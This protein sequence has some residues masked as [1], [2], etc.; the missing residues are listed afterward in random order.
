MTTS[1]SDA[2]R[3]A[4]GSFAIS[5]QKSSRVP[6]AAPDRERK[7]ASAPRRAS[8]P[9]RRCTRLARDPRH[10]SGHTV[11]DDWRSRLVRAFR[12][13]GVPRCAGGDARQRANAG[14]RRPVAD[15][16]QQHVLGAGAGQSRLLFGASG[17]VVDGVFMRRHGL[18]GRV[19]SHTTSGSW[20][21]WGWCGTSLRRRSRSAGPSTSP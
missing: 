1:P 19:R 14:Q 7:P 11:G 15:E 4:G 8:T 6:L 2:S 13:K 10:S 20:W 18:L 3:G 16:H 21:V 9:R 5:M 17:S 12:A